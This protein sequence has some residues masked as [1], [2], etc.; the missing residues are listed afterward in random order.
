MVNIKIYYECEG[1]NEKS[2]LRITHWHYEACRVMT[3]DNREGQIFL[4]NPH[5]NNGLFF[6]LTIKYS[7]YIGKT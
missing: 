5:K 3:N 6:L 4:S 1:G 2:I 7:F